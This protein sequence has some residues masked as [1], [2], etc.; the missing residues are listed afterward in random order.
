MTEHRNGLDNAQ[1]ERFALLVEE[2]G[3]LLQSVGKILR[4]GLY[5]YNPDN[6]KHEYNILELT[7]EIV[8]VNHA[9]GLIVSSGDT[10]TSYAKT[11]AETRPT[12]AEK[13]LYYNK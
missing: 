3:E 13:W 4:H 1:I 5:N 8:D 11:R 7:N 10:D 9:I 12:R 6:P 2:T